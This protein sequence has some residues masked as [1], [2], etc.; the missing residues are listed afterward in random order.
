MCASD[1]QVFYL[2][3]PIW[4]VFYWNWSSWPF[5]IEITRPSQV[6]FLNFRM[7]E[8]FQIKYLKIKANL[9]RDKTR[10][11]FLL[12]ILSEASEKLSMAS[13][14]WCKIQWENKWFWVVKNKITFKFW[15]RVLSYFFNL[16]NSYTQRAKSPFYSKSPKS[17]CNY[18]WYPKPDPIQLNIICRAI[19]MFHHVLFL[20]KNYA[21]NPESL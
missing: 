16:R 2:L 20:Q 21:E 1:H 11:H 12:L 4:I 9:W 7:V 19:L 3:N 8:F 17:S 15:I 6:V 18:I 5:S 14:W 13:L 10:L